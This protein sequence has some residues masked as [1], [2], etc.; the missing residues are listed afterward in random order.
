[1]RGH[2]VNKRNMV[3]QTNLPT[4]SSGA[5]DRR[6]FA[7]FPAT[8]IF[9]GTSRVTTL[10]APTI[11]FSPIV[12]RERTVVPEPIEEPFFTRVV[13]TFQSASVCKCPSEVARG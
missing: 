13:S 2:Q 6:I 1:M 8:I 11:A 9:G 7:G 5:I 12:T 3:V 10:P 4:F